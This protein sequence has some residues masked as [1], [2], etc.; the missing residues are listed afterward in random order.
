MA[1]S[2]EVIFTPMFIMIALSVLISGI[3]G[4][5]F[6]EKI[7]H[8]SNNLLSIKIFA[9][10]ILVNIIIFIFIIMSFRRIK[11]TPGKAGPTG[12][13]GERG[14]DGRDGGL[15]VCSV[16]YQKVQD[17]KQFERQLNYLDL[18]PPV[19]TP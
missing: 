2:Y 1:L 15:S 6:L 19:I 10:S 14:Y 16:Q 18:K 3:V 4:I 12:N 17:K 5:Q 8:G 7:F 9:I 13:R 11:F